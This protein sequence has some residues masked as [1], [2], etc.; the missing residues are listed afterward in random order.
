MVTMLIPVVG[1]IALALATLAAAFVLGMRA[2]SPL[3]LGAVVALSRA[4]VNPRQMLTAGTPGAY[5]GIIRHR[6]RTSGRAYETPVGVVAADDG[7]LIMLPYG[8]AH[9][10]RNVLASGSATLVHEGRTFEVDTP[11]IIPMASVATR[12]S[13]SDQRMARLFR[14]TEVLR[15]RRVAA[16]ARA[17]DAVAL[18]A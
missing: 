8:R 11:E 10:T 1:V 6:G 14:V 15:L 7:F 3:V 4:V 17:H 12:F 18:A 2:R 13:P 16:T 5:A 9:W